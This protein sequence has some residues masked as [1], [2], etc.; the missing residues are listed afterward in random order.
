MELELKVSAMRLAELVETYPKCMGIEICGLI[1]DDLYDDIVEHDGW[2]DKVCPTS[3]LP[4]RIKTSA[5]IS[6]L[7]TTG[8]LTIVDVS[9]E[10]VKP[11]LDVW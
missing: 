3:H 8:T 6:H 11:G 4:S 1:S 9:N 7:L 5:I 10:D 2:E